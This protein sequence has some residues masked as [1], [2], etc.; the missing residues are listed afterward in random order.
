MGNCRH[1]LV[2]AANMSSAEIAAEIVTDRPVVRGC[3]CWVSTSLNWP[4]NPSPTNCG[5]SLRTSFTASGE[6]RTIAGTRLSAMYGRFITILKAGGSASELGGTIRQCPGIG[7]AIL[8]RPGNARTGAGGKPS[9][10]SQWVDGRGQS[11]AELDVARHEKLD[12]R[13]RPDRAVSC[14]HCQPARPLPR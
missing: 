1:G 8:R 10:Q 12:D 6:N 13:R 7:W 11:S 5:M 14:R 4:M 2:R 3:V 9:R